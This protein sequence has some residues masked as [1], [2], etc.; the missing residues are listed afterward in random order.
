VMQCDVSDLERCTR[1]GCD[2]S[3]DLETT[4]LCAKCSGP[5]NINVCRSTFICCPNCGASHF[6]WNSACPEARRARA[7]ASASLGFTSVLKPTASRVAFPSHVTEGV[8]F[9]RAAGNASSVN[10]ADLVQQLSGEHSTFVQ[11]LSQT[12][13]SLLTQTI[14]DFCAALISTVQSPALSPVPVPDRASA[15]AS[16]SASPPVVSVVRMLSSLDWSVLVP[17]L[18]DLLQRPFDPSTVAHK[19]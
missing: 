14:R 19:S 18:L 1:N 8:S 13:V 15:S 6:A 2:T 7:A 3:I 4:P 12:I 17:R 16:T 10:H 11:Q 5:H 9:S